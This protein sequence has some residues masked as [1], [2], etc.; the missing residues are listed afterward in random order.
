MEENLSF[1]LISLITSV[2][3]I[4]HISSA[5]GVLSNLLGWVVDHFSI[6]SR[7]PDVRNHIIEKLQQ[8]EKNSPSN[9]LG[10][11]TYYIPESDLADKSAYEIAQC[12]EYVRERK[13]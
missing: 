4:I 3:S 13:N 10:H 12:P 1:N 6:E 9:G 2:V 7:W 11:Q 5:G 8:Q